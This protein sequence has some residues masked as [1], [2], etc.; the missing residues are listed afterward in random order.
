MLNFRGGGTPVFLMTTRTV[1][2]RR[3]TCLS[4]GGIAGHIVLFDPSAHR[5]HDDGP[6]FIYIWFHTE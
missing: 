5:D 1:R 4:V 6:L 2:S 3:K